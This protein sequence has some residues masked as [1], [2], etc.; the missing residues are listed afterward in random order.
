MSVMVGVKFKITLSLGLVGTRGNERAA[1]SVNRTSGPFYIVFDRARALNYRDFE[2]VLEIGP[3]HR[4]L[5]L[6]P[7]HRDTS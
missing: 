2:H 4:S 6:F 1:L 3:R 7:G 5:P